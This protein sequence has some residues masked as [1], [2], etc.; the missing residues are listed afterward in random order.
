MFRRPL[1]FS[2]LLF[3]SVAITFLLLYL[4]SQRLILDF[5]PEKPSSSQLELLAKDVRIN[6]AELKIRLP[7]VAILPETHKHVCNDKGKIPCYM[8]KEKIYAQE[9]F[10]M[11]AIA[12]TLEEYSSFYDA[13]VEQSI[14][15]PEF[16]P[17][18]TQEW[19]RR[20][21]NTNQLEEH[22]RIQGVRHFYLVKEDYLDS[23]NY[24]SIGE[25]L[26]KVLQKM[27]FNEEVPSH[28]CPPNHIYACVAAIRISDNLLAAWFFGHTEAEK[29]RLV[30][31]A[32]Y[33]KAFIRYGIQET[34]NFEAL[35]KQ[36]NSA[37]K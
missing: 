34:E 19:A 30:K 31:D 2:K 10:T 4:A 17:M 5:K 18:L 13:N 14:G 23:F 24:V 29:L 12:I 33:I 25:G 22:A 9:H 7:V 15:V 32:K 28:Y 6:I 21:C 27:S 20:V 36:L 35:N 11:D 3:L 37:L 1:T 16:C 26:G 8:S